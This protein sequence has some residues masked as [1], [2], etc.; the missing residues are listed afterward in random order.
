MKTTKTIFGALF[1]SSL[2]LGSR[3]IEY[4]GARAHSGAFLID[5]AWEN[6]FEW[7]KQSEGKVVFRHEQLNLVLKDQQNANYLNMINNNNLVMV[8]A[9]KHTV[10]GQEIHNHPQAIA[11]F[12]TESFY[13]FVLIQPQS[14]EDRDALAAAAHEDIAACG[15]MVSVNLD[16]GVT[17]LGAAISPVYATT[18]KLPTAS[19]LAD[20]VSAA[21]I[22]TNDKALEA[23]GSRYH[24]GPNAA[25]AVA[26]VKSMWQAN[27]PAG[28][29]ITEFTNSGGTSQNNVVLTI[30]GTK[31]DNT[32]VIDVIFIVSC[33][34]S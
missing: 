4:R 3:A 27:L 9:S 12:P 14:L 10:L 7:T 33:L 23:L 31:D 19:A 8:S 11:V 29:T 28:A 30:P 22:T 13:D 32:T 25:A 6:T 17:A 18:V 24:A 5:P 20:K 26:K 34:A 16:E 21:N 1:L 15:A 2:L